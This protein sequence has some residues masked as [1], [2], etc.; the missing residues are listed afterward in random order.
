MPRKINKII[1]HH[2]AYSSDDPQVMLVDDWHEQRGFPVSKTGSHVGYHYFI[3]RDGTQMQCR[4]D[5]EVGAHDKGE[6]LNS[7][8]IGLAGNFNIEMP[9]AK[10]EKA[11]GEMLVMLTTR[12]NL[13][14][15][16]IEP[17]RINDNTLC[18]GSK[19][20]DHWAKLIYLNALLSSL[21]ELIAHYKKEKQ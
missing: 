19:L 8:G 6:N 13:N 18:Y 17:H 2:T 21:R 3:E 12:H 5:D 10:Q 15:L 11:L 4:F 9:T 20:S 16:D 1:V 14:V 7:I